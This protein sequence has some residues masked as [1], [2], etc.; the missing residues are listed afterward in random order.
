LRNIG[1]GAGAFVLGI[2]GCSYLADFEGHKVK[3]SQA[4]ARAVEASSETARYNAIESLLISL[5]IR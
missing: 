1:L 3:F 4:E 5:E 2:G